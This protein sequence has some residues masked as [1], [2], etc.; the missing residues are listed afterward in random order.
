MWCTLV[1]LLPRATCSLERGEMLHVSVIFYFN[2]QD[3]IG[4]SKMR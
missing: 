3:L 2:S 1:I 4:E